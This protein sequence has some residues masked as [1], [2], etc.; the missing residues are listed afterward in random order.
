MTR[1]V[2]DIRIAAMVDLTEAEGPGARFALWV[3][4]CSLRCPGCCNPHMFAARGGRSLPVEE[5]LAAAARVRPAI[6]GLTLLGG[7]PFEQAGPLGELARGAQALGLSVVTFTGYALEELRAMLDPGVPALLSATDILVDGRYQP[8]L[9]ERERRWAG[10][11]NQRFHF[12]TSRYQPGIERIAPG[13]AERTVELRF[14][15]DGSLFAN[16]WPEA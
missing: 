5:V 9:P 15:P 12:L 14:G 16:G 7:E 10:S 8:H 2:G 13:E 6:E 4:G 11:S 1:P 3:Q